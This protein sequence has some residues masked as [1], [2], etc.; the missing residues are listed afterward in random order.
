MIVAGW[1]KKFHVVA[2][3]GIRACANCHH[4]AQ[5]FLLQEKREIRLYFV[6]IARWKGKQVLVCS[7][8]SFQ[9]VTAGVEAQEIVRANIGI[10]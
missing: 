2:N 8:C 6:P 9:T 10:S 3:A 7:V 1:R 4:D 5:H